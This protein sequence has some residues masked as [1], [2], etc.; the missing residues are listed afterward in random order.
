MAIRKKITPAVKFGVILFLIAAAYGVCL[1]AI[2][3]GRL[4]SGDVEK[5]ITWITAVCVP[6]SVWC[7]TSMIAAKNLMRQH[8]MNVLLQTRTSAEYTKHAVR[9]SSALRLNGMLADGDMREAVIY[10]LN[11]LEFVAIGIKRCDLDEGIFR[12]AWKTTFEKTV[13]VHGNGL[14]A[15]VRAE[16]KR[17]DTWEHVLW[18]NNRWQHP[19][20]AR[21]SDVF[22]L[23]WTLL[24]G[25]LFMLL[26]LL[27]L[28]CL[29]G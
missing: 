26:P 25:A 17:Q 1:L 4:V 10:V 29:F 3:S 18:L 6:V 24:Y 16:P 27:F 12:D 13:E 23:A 21:L 7:L 22:V 11:F 20:Q 9:A 19:A 28:F 15:E 2:L 5:S 8:S 14:I